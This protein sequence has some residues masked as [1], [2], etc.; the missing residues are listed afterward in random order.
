MGVVNEQVIWAARLAFAG[1]LAWLMSAGAVAAAHELRVPILDEA[2]MSIPRTRVPRLD[3]GETETA[4]T[5]IDGLCA[6]LRQRRLIRHRSGDGSG[7]S[8]TLDTMPWL[9]AAERRPNARRERA[10]FGSLNMPFGHFS[11]LTREL[12]GYGRL[13]GVEF[14]QLERPGSA[15]HFEI[16]LSH[17]AS[18][19][20]RRRWAAAG[21]HE[22]PFARHSRRRWFGN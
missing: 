12:D 18:L 2:V 9:A 10:Y 14:L 19:R 21:E 4:Q 3:T 7:P 17:G 20:L 13:R 8:V 16:G 6:C 1:A 11:L 5:L 22:H 15:W